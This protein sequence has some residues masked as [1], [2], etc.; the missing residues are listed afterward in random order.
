MRIPPNSIL[1][2]LVFLTASAF[3]GPKGPPPPGIPPPPGL[4]IDGSVLA[5]LFIAII[6]GLYKINN[7]KIN[8]KTPL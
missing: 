8:K 1:G 4:P 7:L 6:F 5:L 2:V 3:A